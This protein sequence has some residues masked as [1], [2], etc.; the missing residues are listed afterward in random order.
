MFSSIKSLF[1]AAALLAVLPSSFAQTP[2]PT[3]TGTAAAEQARI[4][5]CAISIE[6]AGFMYEYNYDV[7]DTRQ[8]S[9]VYTYSYE[10]V[11]L[12]RVKSLQLNANV[13]PYQLVR[14][15]RRRQSD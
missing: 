10:G 3:A 13:T 2:A 9:Q 7:S 14:M 12:R 6:T 11:L 4:Q 1:A 8:Y 5:N 15:S